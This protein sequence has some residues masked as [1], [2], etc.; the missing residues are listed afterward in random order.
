MS[1]DGHLGSLRSPRQPNIACGKRPVMPARYA[2]GLRSVSRH[3]TPTARRVAQPTRHTPRGPNQPSHRCVT[4]TRVAHAAVAVLC[5]CAQSCGVS[6]AWITL[7]VQ[8]AAASRSNVTACWCAVRRSFSGRAA[9][10][11][12]G[13]HIHPHPRLATAASAFPRPQ[14]S[15]SRRCSRFG[16]IVPCCPRTSA[17]WEPV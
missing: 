4:M 1:K 11:A 3:H 13:F 12:G 10:V 7:R 2:R 5:R 14:S 15:R 8:Q 17:S 6:S 16:E 9:A